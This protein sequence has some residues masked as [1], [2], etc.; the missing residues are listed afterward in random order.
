VTHLIESAQKKMEAGDIGQARRVEAM[1]AA[2]RQIDRNVP[3]KLV[4]E[5][6]F[7]KLE[8]AK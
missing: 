7:L 6:L 4:L 1:L 5:T 8:G 2:R 3:P